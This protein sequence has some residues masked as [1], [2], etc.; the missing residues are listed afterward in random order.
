MSPTLASLLVSLLMSQRLRKYASANNKKG[1]E[2]LFTVNL[3]FSSILFL[4]QFAFHSP[5][6]FRLVWDVLLVSISHLYAEKG[7]SSI[8]DVYL[9]VYSV[10]RGVGGR[11]PRRIN[12]R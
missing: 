1:W 10:Y 6:F 4:T 12:K 7:A 8:R 9:G 3:F 5:M 2:F 11:P